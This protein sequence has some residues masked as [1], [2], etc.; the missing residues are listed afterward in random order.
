M[1]INEYQAQIRNFAM[2]PKELGPYYTILG[3]TSETGNLANKLKELLNE[4][5]NGLDDKDKGKIAISIGDIMFWL[6]SMASDLG[7]EFDEI[8]ALN[9]RKKALIKE[10]MIK[11]ENK[12][13]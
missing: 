2:Y 9:L 5:K 10:K 4:N 1:E 3:V 13:S 7:L 11:S 6:S 12:K 8:I